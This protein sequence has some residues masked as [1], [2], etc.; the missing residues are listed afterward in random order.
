MFN[1]T[2]LFMYIISFLYVAGLETPEEGR[3]E[4]ERE[5]GAETNIHLEVSILTTIYTT[6]PPGL[7]TG[8]L[9]LLPLCTLDVCT[10]INLFLYKASIIPILLC[11]YM[12]MVKVLLNPQW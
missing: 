8:P 10:A 7:L 9:L 4:T 11:F 12:P 6:I 3:R 2:E 5:G 1:V